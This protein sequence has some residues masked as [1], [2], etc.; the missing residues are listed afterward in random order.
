MPCLIVSPVLGDV[1]GAG[2]VSLHGDG[3][4]IHPAGRAL[5][6]AALEVTN[7]RTCPPQCAIPA[8]PQALLPSEGEG[9]V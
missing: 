9:G 5:R 1:C 6:G 8:W 4:H 2:A 3:F 7:P